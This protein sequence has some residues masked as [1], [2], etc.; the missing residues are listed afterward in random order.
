LRINESSAKSVGQ[1]QQKSLLP[2]KIEAS[3]NAY[4][5]AHYSDGT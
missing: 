5:D 1:A 3:P 4:K 2:E